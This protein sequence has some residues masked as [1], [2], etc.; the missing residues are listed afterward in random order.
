ML[1]FANFANAARA[2]VDPTTSPADLAT[3]AELQPGLWA[4]VAGHPNAYPDLLTWLD[5]V[6]DTSVKAALAARRQSEAGAPAYVSPRPATQPTA[7]PATAP[8]Y[9]QTR[10]LA[11]AQ[12][13]QKSPAAAFF[14]SKR[15]RIAM[16][17]A[18]V[19]IL[20]VIVTLVLVFQ[21]FVPRSDVEGQFN[22]ALAAYNK[23]QSALAA[24]VAVAQSTVDASD[25]DY[26]TDPSTL[27][28]LN[29]TLQTAATNSKVPPP[30]MGTSTGQIRS[31]VNAMQQQ[32]RSMDDQ[33]TSLATAVS[34]VQ[35]NVVLW[36]K[37]ALTTAISD[38][39]GAYTQY[40]YSTDTDSLAALQSQI[41]S[42]QNTLAAVDRMD[43]N[44][45]TMTVL[46]ALTDLSK[47]QQAVV[48]SAPVHCGDVILPK[49]VDARACGAVPDG[50]VTLPSV[51]QWGAMFEMP[52]HNIGCYPKDNGITCEIGTHKWTAP[53]D[54]MDTCKTTNED[55]TQCDASMIVIDSNGVVG[56]G[57]H[58]DVPQWKAAKFEGVTVPVLQ[59]GNA[60]DYSP[61]ACVSAE[62][63]LTCWNTYTHH[64]FKMST[65]TFVSW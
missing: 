30:T 55:P 61:V 62:D 56:V 7:R 57:Y 27:D 15:G 41:S 20:A 49:G 48:A 37:S 60:I 22:D 3:I 43:P 59:Y 18:G 9:Q 8:T 11:S 19:V 5:V 4:Q 54:L 33:T 38:A 40:S 39:N 29:K 23:S 28:T 31:Q 47:A 6:G 17:A 52:S 58:Q 14:G 24:E 13:P 46:Q 44:S 1:D 25:A 16:I 36:A 53:S 21:V 45:V 50:A 26:L 12:P 51:G 42:A 32:A 63:G 10:P 34:N 65:S 35:A 64:G 2:V